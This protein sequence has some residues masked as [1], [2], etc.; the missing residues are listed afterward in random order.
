VIYATYQQVYV[1]IQNCIFINN[2]ALFGGLFYI[3]YGSYFYIYNSTMSNNFGILGG[4]AYI[5]N[6]GS[7]YIDN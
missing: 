6:D 1:L 4:I 2:Y 3:D 7:I 5:N